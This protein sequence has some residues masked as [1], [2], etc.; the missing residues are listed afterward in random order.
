MFELASFT[1]AVPVVLVWESRGIERNGL[2]VVHSFHL[3]GN[4]SK[5]TARYSEYLVPVT[6]ADSIIV[7]V[8]TE[9]L[10]VFAYN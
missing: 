9:T 6:G 3:E 10:A 5:L 4:D 1:V 2:R 8:S 7:T